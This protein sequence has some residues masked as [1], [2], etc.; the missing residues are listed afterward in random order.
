MRRSTGKNKEN[1]LPVGGDLQQQQ[2]HSL[3]MK[4]PK[5]VF[6]EAGRLEEVNEME[7][8]KAKNCQ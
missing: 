3:K 4:F 7:N 2:Q 6:D 1:E 8:E 5:S